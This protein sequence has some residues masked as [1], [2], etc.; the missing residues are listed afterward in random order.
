Q[1]PFYSKSS[2]ESW[3][4]NKPPAIKQRRF[5]RN[6]QRLPNRGQSLAKEAIEASPLAHI[7]SFSK[8]STF[9]KCLAFEEDPPLFWCIFPVVTSISDTVLLDPNAYLGTL[10]RLHFMKHSEINTWQEE[11]D[12]LHRGRFSYYWGL[13]QA[14]CSAS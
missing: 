8:C 11:T 7:P 1:I 2:E 9:N 3:K 6:T 4:A 14:S 13:H 5:K 12:R 10:A